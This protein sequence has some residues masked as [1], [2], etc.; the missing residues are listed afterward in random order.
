MREKERQTWEGLLKK[1][2]RQWPWLPQMSK[3]ETTWF[4]GDMGRLQ[5]GSK[6]EVQP[7]RA[8][9]GKMWA[10]ECRQKEAPHPGKPL[11]AHPLLTT[12]QPSKI[13]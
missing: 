7:L 12:H 8:P 3:V 13:C 2:V 1:V 9:S 6:W 10:F 11:S 5:C 4:L